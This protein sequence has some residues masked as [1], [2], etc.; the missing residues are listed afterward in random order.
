MHCLKGLLLLVG[1]V[2]VL[3]ITG[4]Q[5]P[6]GPGPDAKPDLVAVKPSP[7]IP[8]EPGFCERQ[9]QNLL[10]SIKNQGTTDAP[11]STTRVD[12]TP[13]KTMS[14]VVLECLWNSLPITASPRWKATPIKPRP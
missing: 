2:A 12:F 8:G 3:A 10:V 13:A 9:G 7:D 1:L 4:C 5:A 14:R 6:P 11:P